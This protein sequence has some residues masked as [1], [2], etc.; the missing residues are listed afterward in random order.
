L[1]NR[2]QTV[3]VTLSY[4]LGVLGWLTTNSL[5]G[6]YALMDQRMALQWVQNNI[7]SFG[8]NSNQV[9]KSES[10]FFSK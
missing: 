1:A 2:T 3:V 8:G 6:N 4:R 5:T 9:K 7:E 10:F